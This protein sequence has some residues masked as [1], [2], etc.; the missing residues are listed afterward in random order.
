MAPAQASPTEHIPQRADAARVLEE[1]Q[2]GRR[3]AGLRLQAPLNNLPELPRQG[4]VLCADTWGGE[5][6]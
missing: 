2:G 1:S 3:P 4:L 5:V 6:R